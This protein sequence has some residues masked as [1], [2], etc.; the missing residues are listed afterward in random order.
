MNDDIL[1]LSLL[2]GPL[3]QHCY[4]KSGPFFDFPGSFFSFEKISKQNSFWTLTRSDTIYIFS[5]LMYFN[6]LN[7]F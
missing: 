7:L 4:K 3:Y 6:L 1:L 5:I 2:L